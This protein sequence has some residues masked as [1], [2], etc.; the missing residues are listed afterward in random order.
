M[1]GKT[2][3]T[4]NRWRNR[5]ARLKAMGPQKKPAMRA[6]CGKAYKPTGCTDLR[7]YS[8]RQATL[9]QRAP[10]VKEAPPVP[11]LSDTEWHC[12]LPSLPHFDASQVAGPLVAAAERKLRALTS[13]NS[14]R[15]ATA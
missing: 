3:N 12:E 2:T 9:C 4:A 6:Y 11:I 7:P 5:Q 14:M 8:A 10:K 1:A 13:Y 15:Q